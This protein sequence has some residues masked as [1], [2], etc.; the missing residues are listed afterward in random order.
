MAR[1]CDSAVAPDATPGWGGMRRQL[2]PW[3]GCA[4]RSCL[5]ARAGRP[6]GGPAV[7][8]SHERSSSLDR[9]RQRQAGEGGCGS[10]EPLA[11]NDVHLHPDN[12]VRHDSLPVAQRTCQVGCLPCASQSLMSR[13]GKPLTETT[14]SRPS[15][16]RHPYPA[17][18][19]SGFPVR[20][21]REQAYSPHHRHGESTH[22][23][24]KAPGRR[25]G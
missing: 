17:T 9:L 15:M 6:S 4:A 7:R 21:R 19:R 18:L 3:T 14:G 2:Q 22:E 23:D 13:P 10:A 5:A 25:L 20:R 1:A 12:S 11:G 8:P 24:P 16:T